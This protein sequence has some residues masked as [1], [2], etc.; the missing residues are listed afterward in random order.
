MQN[1][2]LGAETLKADTGKQKAESRNEGGN[3]SG[4][5]EYAKYAEGCANE[6]EGGSVLPAQRHSERD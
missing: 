2:E 3:T 6:R 4:T 5:A 1:A